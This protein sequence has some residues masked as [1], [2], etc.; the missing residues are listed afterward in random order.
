MNIDLTMFTI[1]T[2]HADELLQGFFIGQVRTLQN[3]G[4]LANAAIWLNLLVIFMSMGVFA[5][6][7]PNYSAAFSQSSG[8]AIS[9]P[10]GYL[11]RIPLYSPT[12]HPY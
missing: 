5:H 1:V 3:Y 12:I 7:I 9:G 11:G 2:F 6:T 10:G 4:W 8:A